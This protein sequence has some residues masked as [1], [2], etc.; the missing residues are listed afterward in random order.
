MAQYYYT[1]AR[2]QARLCRAEVHAKPPQRP[3]DISTY[4]TGRSRQ[5]L[6]GWVQYSPY[7]HTYIHTSHSRLR[8]MYA[9]HTPYVHTYGI[10]T[11]QLV[12]LTLRIMQ[13]NVAVSFI[14][15][16]LLCSYMYVHNSAQYIPYRTVRRNNSSVD[17]FHQ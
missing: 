16:Y 1:V 5:V 4:P 6:Y 7:I 14:P 8:T 11:Q 17:S 3:H 12:P 2:R 13:N 15:A 9:V 10:H